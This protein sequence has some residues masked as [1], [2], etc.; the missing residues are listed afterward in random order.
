MGRVSWFRAKI[1]ACDAVLGEGAG[2][3]GDRAA[4]RSAGAD[5]K[6]RIHRSAGPIAGGTTASEAI[7]LAKNRQA[8]TASTRATA[9]TVAGAVTSAGAALRTTPSND[10][11]T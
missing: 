11:S 6:S 3:K 1:G 8:E 4:R 9:T 7:C 5:A 10:S 2:I